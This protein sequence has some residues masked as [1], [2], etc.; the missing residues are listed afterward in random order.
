MNQV[1][2]PLK[3]GTQGYAIVDKE[4]SWMLN[5][6]WHKGSY[7]YA[8]GKIDGKV[9]RLHHI[10]MPVKKG[11]DVDHI[12]QDKL[13]NT[14]N[15]LRYTSRSINSLNSS[16]IKGEIPFR[17]VH[18]YK[19]MFRAKIKINGKQIYLGL[20]KTPEKAAKAYLTKQKELIA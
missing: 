6:K 18:R 16:H 15:N 1:E 2:I 3:S 5:H 12:N 8:T 4:Y 11:F 19:D 7:G 9:I 20:Y 17:G 13:D 10:I 14:S